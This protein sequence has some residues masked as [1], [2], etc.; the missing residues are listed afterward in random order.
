MQDYESEMNDI[1]NS[2]NININTEGMNADIAHEEVRIE[3]NHVK[4][5]KSVGIDLLPNEVLRTDPV[6]PFL[7]KHFNMCFKYGIVPSV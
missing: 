6:Y 2:E 5:C 7:S 1:I 3:L 4:L